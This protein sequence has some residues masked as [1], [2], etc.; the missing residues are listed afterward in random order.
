MPVL[1]VSF[2]DYRALP[3]LNWSTLR[4]LE[5]SSPLHFKHSLDAPEDNASHFIVGRAVH[6][7]VLE[8]ELFDEE[9][10]TWPG[11]LTKAGQPTQNRLSAAFKSFARENTGK[12]ILTG[13]DQRTVHGC[14]SSV[15]GHRVASRIVNGAK[16]EQSVTWEDPLT[17]IECKCRV[18]IVSTTGRVADLK[19]TSEISPREFGQSVVKYGYSG[20][21]AFYL[22]GAVAG[23]LDVDPGQPPA[24][25]AVESKPPYDCIVY[26]VDHDVLAHGRK[27]YK[28]LLAQYARIQKSKEWAGWA[29]DSELDI[30]LPGWAL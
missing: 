8:P 27:L 13:D 29:P 26:R 4:R 24:L 3:Q 6:T 1:D 25:V 11:G 21:V 10:I 2:P 14:I 7:G 17:G 28:N 20:Q 5:G 15:S 30:V 12:T 18:D 22:D 16:T 9:Y 23:G 19:T